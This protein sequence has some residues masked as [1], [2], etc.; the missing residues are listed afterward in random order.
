MENITTVSRRL[1]PRVVLVAG[2]HSW[3]GKKT[4]DWH[5]KD[6]LFCNYLQSIGVA[7]V[8]H[9]VGGRPFVWS[10]NLG[11]LN[12]FSKGDLLVWEAAGHSLY[13]YIVPPLAP[14]MRIPPEHTVIVSH[15]HGLQ[16]VLY[17]A[18]LGLQIDTLIDVAGPVRGDMMPVAEQARPHIRR[19]HHV[20]AGRRDKWQLGGQFL[21]GVLG[22]VRE[23]PLAQNVAIKDANHG[24]VLRTMRYF[25]VVGTRILEP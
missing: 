23:H 14:K 18:S 16:V 17:A 10:T 21:D 12:P 9:K 22:F 4:S 20:H 24:D 11:G 6:S 13:S 3:R 8:G 1:N 5:V 15:S 2:T 7:V 19:W 25:G